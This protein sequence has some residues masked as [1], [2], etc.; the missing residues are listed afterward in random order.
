MSAESDALVA[1]T[2]QMYALMQE[3]KR[4][5]VRLLHA[6]DAGGVNAIS[7]LPAP[8]VEA[9]NDDL[10][11]IVDVLAANTTT[12]PTISVSGLGPIPIVWANGNAP[13]AGDVAGSILFR[14][15]ARPS[16]GWQAQILARNAPGGGGG[17][18]GGGISA[19]SHDAT[20]SGDGAATPL[21]AVQA[22]ET[23]R[24]AMEV[25]T[26]A[27]AK[28]GVRD[29]VAITPKKLAG[30][31]VGGPGVNPGQFIIQVVSIASMGNP[32]G[33]G[34]RKG[35]SYTAAEIQGGAWVG[36]AGV[37]CRIGIDGAN[38]GWQS[39]NFSPPNTMS[40]NGVMAGNW[41]LET[42]VWLGSAVFSDYF[43]ALIYTRKP[44]V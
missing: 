30:S 40:I 9:Y 11:L 32:Y 34:F 20:L 23:Q 17:G 19:V 2:A 39:G 26:L 16:G 5:N 28:A 18:G 8:A 38:T 44:N 13:S 27:E 10:V 25:A 29:D 42:W 12:T 31:G 35:N 22:T 15:A 36:V 37:T 21:S 1:A 43:Y 41:E 7:I 4:G 3:L 24:G 6:A 14:V 33:A